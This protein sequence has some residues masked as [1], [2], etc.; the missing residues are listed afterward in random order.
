MS[1]SDSPDEQSAASPRSSPVG[2]RV[3]SIPPAYLWRAV[4]LV[5]NILTPDQIRALKIDSG[6]HLALLLTTAFLQAAPVSMDVAGDHD[7]VF[8][9][10]GR[11]PLAI[12]AAMLGMS[13]HR[14]AD[15]EVK[16]L[17]G[18]FRKFNA[19]LDKAIRHRRPPRRTEFG[20]KVRSIND[21]LADEGRRMIT[22]A[23]TQLVARQA[24]LVG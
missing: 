17:P 10:S 23:R 12:P 3:V 1:P 15:F 6:E 11:D 9:L 7:L 14:H 8:D 4:E 2:S 19:D 21:I 20:A 18:G 24:T 13:E 16:S 5:S 22:T